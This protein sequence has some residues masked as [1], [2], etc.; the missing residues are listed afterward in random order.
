MKV[1]IPDLKEI[2]HCS[3]IPPRVRKSS[4]YRIL[5]E[6]SKH[7]ENTVEA[8]SNKQHF[9]IAIFNQ[10]LKTSKKE[11]ENITLPFSLVNLL[12]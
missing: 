6:K 12:L 7:F 2:F 11:I 3:K 5:T 10:E 9:W 4:I 1:K 8:I